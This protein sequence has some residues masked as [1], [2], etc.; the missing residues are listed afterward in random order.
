MHFETGVDN[1]FSLEEK[2]EIG[3][4]FGRP[5][6]REEVD[7][8]IRG[9][10][11]ESTY[12]KYITENGN[13][14]SSE[15]WGPSPRDIF[16]D[17]V[18]RRQPSQWS[19]NDINSFLNKDIEYTFSVPTIPKNKNLGLIYLGRSILRNIKKISFSVSF[20][21]YENSNTIYVS[22]NID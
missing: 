20:R 1:D 2:K 13:R 6:T 19:Y 15:S 4:L 7:Q 12:I 5:F 21:L 9:L 3:L 10:Y 17:E 11:D 14:T 18:I 8:I 16:I 22:C